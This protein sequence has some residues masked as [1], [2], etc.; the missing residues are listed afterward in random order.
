MSCPLCSDWEFVPSLLPL[1]PTESTVLQRTAVVRWEEQE[2]EGFL[3]A[4]FILVKVR[5]WCCPAQMQKWN[6]CLA[7]TKG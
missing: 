1:L 4:N 7:A 5:R 6:P 2:N 3:K